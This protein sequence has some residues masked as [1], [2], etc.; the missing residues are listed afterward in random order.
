M[1]RTIWAGSI[2]MFRA[3]NLYQPCNAGD[4]HFNQHFYLNGPKHTYN[5]QP[6]AFS[7][8]HLSSTIPRLKTIQQQH[9]K[10]NPHI[11]LPQN[12]SPKSPSCAQRRGSRAPAVQT[13]PAVAC[14]PHRSPLHCEGPPAAGWPLTTRRGARSWESPRPSCLG[15]GWGKCSVDFCGKNCCTGWAFRKNLG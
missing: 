4:H 12:C 7:T 13:S 2:S 8:N 10:K 1:S 5:S 14:H 15:R 3:D 6:S 9:E 11:K